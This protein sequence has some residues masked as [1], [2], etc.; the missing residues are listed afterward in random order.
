[1]KRRKD[2]QVAEDIGIILS[3]TVSLGSIALAIIAAWLWRKGVFWALGS[4]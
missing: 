1:M 4:G 2:K 3:L